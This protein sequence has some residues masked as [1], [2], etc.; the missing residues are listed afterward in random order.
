MASRLF[1]SADG[2]FV[3]KIIRKKV[4][5]VFAQE[6][7]PHIDGEGL[8]SVDFNPKLRAGLF[9]LHAL[10]DDSFVLFSSKHIGK[11]VA[12]VL[13]QDRCA[14]TDGK[15]SVLHISIPNLVRRCFKRSS[16]SMVRGF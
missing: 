11:F 7:N 15:R 2:L 3:N 9:S 5:P 1:S 4:A 16:D 13:A 6:R 14:Y 10:S 8:V 12:P